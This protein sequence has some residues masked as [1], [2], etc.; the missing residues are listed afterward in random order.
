MGARC[1]STSM[2]MLRARHAVQS[3]RSAALG[4]VKGQPAASCPL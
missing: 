1:E 4:D 3:Q 2:D